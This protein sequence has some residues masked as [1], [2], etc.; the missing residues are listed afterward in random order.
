MVMIT[1][2]IAYITCLVTNDTGHAY[3]VIVVIRY[4]TEL[5]GSYISKKRQCCGWLVRLFVRSGPVAF[6]GASNTVVG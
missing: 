6:N 3:S 4:I 1:T 2:H 5:V